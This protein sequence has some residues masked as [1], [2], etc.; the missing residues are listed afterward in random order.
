[1]FVNTTGYHNV[2]IGNYALDAKT[3]GA[4]NTAVGTNTLDANTTAS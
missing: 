3:T 4:T 2:A 1:M